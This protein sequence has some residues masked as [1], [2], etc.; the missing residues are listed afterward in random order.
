MWTRK[1]NVAVWQW[2]VPSHSLLILYLRRKQKFNKFDI[3]KISF[4]PI[5]AISSQIMNEPPKYYFQRLKHFGRRDGISNRLCIF[6]K[7]HFLFLS[8]SKKIIGK[9]MNSNF[10]MNQL[11]LSWFIVTFGMLDQFLSICEVKVR[12]VLMW[13]FAVAVFIIFV[14]WNW[15]EGFVIT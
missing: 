10:A 5:V 9:T 2:P 13:D 15:N 3:G 6:W 8:R 14:Q 7:D 11:S 1:Q 12:I 4:F